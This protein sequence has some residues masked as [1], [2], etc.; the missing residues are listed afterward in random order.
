MPE[1]I[2]WGF[3]LPYY[4]TSCVVGYLLGSFPTGVVLSKLFG[5]ADLRKTGSGNIGAT[6]AL[7][8]GSKGLAAGTLFGDGG[9]AVLAVWLGGMFGPQTAILAAVFVLLGHLYPVWLGFKGG[10]GIAVYIGALGVLFYP[11]M[12]VF[13]AVWILTAAIFRYSSLAAL[14]AA[15]AVPLAAIYF[16]EYQLRDL[17][18]FFLVMLFISHRDNIKKLWRREESKIGQKNG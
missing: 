1:P 4:L 10:K 9:K 13:T 6:N 17:T 8:T 16:E 7:R 2:D 14:L 3:A 15:V 18:L 12:L 5:F 11:L